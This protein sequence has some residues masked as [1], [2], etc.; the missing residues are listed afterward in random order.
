MNNVKAI[1]LAGGK[2]TRMKSELP[3]VLHKVYDRCIID[4]VY[5]SCK[6]AGI[7]DI[8]IVVGHKYEKVIE[9]FGKENAKFFIQEEQ[10]GTGHAVMQVKDNI[11]ENDLVIV[12]NGDMPLISSFTIKSFVSFLQL[13]NFD[14]ALASAVFDKTPSYGRIVRDNEGNFSKI[15][16]QKDCN[17]DELEIEEVNIGL[18]S[19]KGKHL[20]DSFSKLNNNNAQKEYYITD[21]PYYIMNDGGKVGVYML[22]DSDE[23]QGINSRSDLSVVTNTLLHNTREI[24]MDNGVT[25]IDPS[26]TY[27]S[28]DVE[29]GKDTIIYP[30]TNIQGRTKIGEGCI[31]GP[32][33]TIVCSEIGNYV[34]VE[35]SKIAYSKIADNAIIGPFAH[36]RPKSNIGEFSKV[37]S[38]VETKNV[39]IGTNTKVPHLSYIGDSDVGNNVEIACGVITSNMNTKWEKNR[40]II[41]D[42]AFIG[43]NSVL[44]APITIEEFGAIGAGSTI[45]KD[46]PSKALALTRSEL[47]IKENYYEGR[48]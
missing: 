6:Q 23:T 10:L 46:V 34:I 19:F 31:I 43:C 47:K 37:G 1:I 25:L 22:Q 7:D 11:K 4:Y 45:S 2:G 12:I 18:Y 32:N 41:K 33:S 16:E 38:F 9:H 26:N 40:T 27:I 29:I 8:S 42:N 3:K 39:N 36:I 44:I 48:K 17:E 24:H 21:I 35:T 5:D 28:L 20:L 13:G 30:G 14:G 15:V